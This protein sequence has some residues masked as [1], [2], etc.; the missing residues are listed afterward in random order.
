[1]TAV[2]LALP[3]YRNPGMLRIQFGQWV[4]LAH[5]LHEVI[6]VDDG[7]PAGETAAEV[8]RPPGLPPLLILRH[9]EDRP[10]HQDAARNL[11]MDHASGDL[12]LA[13]DMDHVLTEAALQ[14]AIQQHAQSR[15]DWW[16][17]WRRVQPG[18][19]ALPQPHCNS[20]AMPA[21][22]WGRVGPYDEAYCGIYG[23]DG[24]WGARAQQA[25][26]KPLVSHAPL[27]CYG[28]QHQHD[29]STRGPRKLPNRYE[30]KAAVAD[31]KRARGVT[32]PERIGMK[33]V[34]DVDTRHER[35]RRLA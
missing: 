23:T 2:S 16:M 34:V 33:F 5:L 28:R 6:V 20:W 35:A 31:D 32:A 17:L 19:K 13:L 26:G 4:R 22:C 7:S 12:L 3:Y 1:V 30:L 21:H 14:A 29:A 24:L 27:I 15:D 8:E 25:L 10:W 18:G 11:G 9:L